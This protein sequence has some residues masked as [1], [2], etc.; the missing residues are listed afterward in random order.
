MILSTPLTME[1]L[2]IMLS[3]FKRTFVTKS[4]LY[5][6]AMQTAALNGHLLPILYTYLLS[7][8]APIEIPIEYKEGLL[9]LLFIYIRATSYSAHK[10]LEKYSL[11][12]R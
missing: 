12:V 5:G 7:R 3:S 10:L 6:P 2:Y 4:T 11:L 9:N 1:S 8:L